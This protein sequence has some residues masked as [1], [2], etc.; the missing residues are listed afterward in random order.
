MGGSAAVATTI[1]LQ[2]ELVVPKAIEDLICKMQARFRGY[3]A[4]KRMRQVGV[5]WRGGRALRGLGL[6]RC[7]CCRLLPCR[8]MLVS[9]IE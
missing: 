2:K 9:V 7:C 4:R 6:R 5:P 8:W 3:L 1:G